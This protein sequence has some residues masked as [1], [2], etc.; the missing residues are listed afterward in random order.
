MHDVVDRSFDCVGR[1]F[2]FG[3]HV[4]TGVLDLVSGGSEPEDPPAADALPVVAVGPVPP[5]GA[6]STQTMIENATTEWVRDMRIRSTPLFGLAGGRTIETT[7]VSFD[8]FTVDVPPNGSVAV[9][10]T[11]TVP[12][13]AEGGRYSGF[14]DAAPWRLGVLS[15]FVG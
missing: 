5:G 10:V 4:L 15:V 9:A 8:P 13:T 7:N 3:W 14:V 1:M 12:A 11:V 2:G 6:G